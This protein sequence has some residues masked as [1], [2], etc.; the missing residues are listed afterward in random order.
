MNDKI[1]HID[2]DPSSISKRVKVDIPIVGDVKDVLT[3]MMEMLKEAGL[4]PD[5]HALGAWWDTINGWRKR[6]LFEIR[7]IEFQCDQAS[8]CD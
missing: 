5:S 8:V 4:K 6:E 2:I 1:I 3:E 7:P